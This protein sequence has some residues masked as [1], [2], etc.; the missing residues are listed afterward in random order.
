MCGNTSCAHLTGL[1]PVKV[2][3]DVSVA[4]KAVCLRLWM[5]INAVCINAVQATYAWQATAV[6]PPMAVSSNVLVLVTQQ[7]EPPRTNEKK[8]QQ[9]SNGQYIFVQAPEP[10]EEGLLADET[11]RPTAG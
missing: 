5:Y 10:E 4:S 3:E 2:L 11:G 7:F 6:A 1:Q 8:S 9:T